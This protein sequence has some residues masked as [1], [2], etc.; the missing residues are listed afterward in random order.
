VVQIVLSVVAII[1][2][3]ALALILFQIVR[4]RA[5]AAEAERLVPVAGQFVEVDGNRIHY[6]DRGQGRP[7]LFIHGLGAQLH[8]FFGPLF[9]ELDGFRLVAIDRPGSGYSVRAKG[10]SGRP[11][12]QARVIAGLIDALKLEKPLVVGHSLGGAVALALALNHPDRVAGLALLSP[13]V[14]HRTE[15]APEFAPLHIPSPLRRW[16][17]SHTVAVPTAKKYADATLAY[18]F[19]PQSPPADYMTKGGG[20]LGLRPAHFYGSSTDVT[21][22]SGDYPALEQRYG[23]IKLPIGI[24]F[25]TA[26]KVLDYRA[27]GLDMVGKIPGLDLELLEGVGHMPQFAEPKRTAD[28]IRRMAAKAFG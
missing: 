23:E 15:V 16:A 20:S 11:T 17:V 28:F 21:D 27:N 1:V 3:A 4:T 24:L 6:V 13:H 14:R 12:E 25:G 26:D 7:I 8:Q 18:V 22:I 19:D 5:I 10:S 2:L 9:P